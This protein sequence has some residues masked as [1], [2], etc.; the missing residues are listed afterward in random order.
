MKMRR[1]GMRKTKFV[2]SAT[3]TQG[4]TWMYRDLYLPWL[5]HH[6]RLNLT[7]EEATS[8]Q[9]HPRLW[10]W[11]RGGIT[12]NPGADA[13]D[14]DWYA[15]Q[16]FNSEAERAVRMNGG[17]AD[18]SGQPVFDLEA[19]G[20]GRGPPPRRAGRRLRGGREGKEP[21][22][23]AGAV[24]QRRPRPHDVPRLPGVQR[25]RADGPGQGDDLRAP[26]RR[27]R[28]TCSATTSR[29]GLRGG[30]YDA[31]V[32]IER[33]TGRVVA[34]AVGHWGATMWPEVLW[35]LGWY[36]FHAFLCGER[37]V[38]LFTMR[39]LYDEMGY[40]YQY[41]NRDDET[42]GRTPSEKL[43]H[44]RRQ[45][46]QTIPRLRTAIGRRLPG[47]QPHRAGHH[48]PRP[49]AAPP[50]REVPV[51]PAARV[52]RDPRMPRRGPGDGGAQ[53]ATTTT[54]CWRPGTA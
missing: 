5:Q 33:D 9:W 22:R 12:S 38:G 13:G 29:Y 3:A 54:W 21:R 36:Y 20:A 47:R 50:A 18:F 49:G 46:D 31:A 41:L 7:E 28:S 45:G 8:R 27:A 30:D 25:E 48:Q 16:T 53:G 26:A 24:S 44:H 2:F 19:P 4:M 14:R 43:G 39:R 34:T 23:P 51:P 32:V 35:G 11:A 15:S 17:F 52:G 1:R 37:Q 10:V 6:R 42:P 40:T